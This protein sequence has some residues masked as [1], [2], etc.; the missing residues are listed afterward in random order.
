VGGRPAGGSGASPR[1][2]PE[3]RRGSLW[4]LLILIAVV[5]Y[6]PALTG[7]FVSDD[8]VFYE[9]NERLAEA[10]MWDVLTTPYGALAAQPI[11]SPLY[12]PVMGLVMKATHALWGESAPMY[13]L[14]SLVLHVMA[15]LLVFRLVS[16]LAGPRSPWAPAAGAALFAAHPVHV[17]AVVWISSAAHLL[18]TIFVVGSVLSLLE[19]TERRANGLLMASLGLFALGLLTLEVVVTLPLFFL[20]YNRA[21]RGNW[22]LRE[23]A[24]FLAVLAAYFVVRTQ[25][26]GAAVPVGPPTAESFGV[27]LQFAVGYVKSFVLPWPQYLYLDVPRGG[28]VAP[29]AYGLAMCVLAGAGLLWTRAPESVR[30]T[31]RVGLL[32]M[33]VFLI[34]SLAASLHERPLFA[35]R[36]MYLSSVGLAVMGAGAVQWVPT[37][38]LK[39]VAA[40]LVLTLV[41]WGAMTLHA[42]RPWKDDISLHQQALAGSPGSAGVLL[43]LGRI[44]EG[45]GNDAAAEGFLLGAVTNARS[46]AIEADAR[47]ALA[48][49]HG[50]RGRIDSSEAEYRAVLELEPARSSA[51]VGLGNNAWA[52]GDMSRALEHYVRAVGLDGGNY[53]AAYNAGLALS[54]LGNAEGASRY[55]DLAA[56]LGS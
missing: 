53:E 35:P 3:W 46:T 36:S 28:L 5:P 24:P 47:E 31:I 56:R 30:P 41:M 43:A 19:Y 33:A 10:T 4:A 7:S 44:H 49:F 2:F 8:V 42:G 25:V 14:L 16:V 55:F 23:V 54:A 13:H 32:W 15:T 39:T 52:R 26:L 37:P 27:L 51:W 9:G 50:E 17:E 6:L 11:T 34:P 21:A 48:L 1:S 22:G 29:G 18:A 45:A 12:R 38:R 40:V 20:A